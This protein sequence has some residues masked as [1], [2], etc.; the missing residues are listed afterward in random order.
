MK[1]KDVLVK[2]YMDVYDQFA[3]ETSDVMSRCSLSRSEALAAL[4]ELESMGLVAGEFHDGNGR[5]GLRRRDVPGVNKLWQCWNTYDYE[6]RETALARVNQ[7][8]D[9]TK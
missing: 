8:L 9:R 4:N 1:N 7:A 6:D 2:V 3:L 5:M